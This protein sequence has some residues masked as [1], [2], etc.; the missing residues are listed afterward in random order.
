MTLQYSDLFAV[1][2]GATFEQRVQVAMASAAAAVYAESGFANTSA[3]SASGLKTLQFA[4]ATF[5]S[6]VV[7]G[8]IIVD[9]TAPAGISSG[10]II[11][12]IVT[13]GGTT[14]LTLS[15]PLTGT[16]GTGDT[17]GFP[18][19]ATRAAFANRVSQGNY[20]LQAA[21]VMVFSN[22]TIAAEAALATA[23]NSIPDTDLQFAVNS[24]WNMMAGT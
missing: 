9:L 2:A 17:V 15:S 14:T 20:N 22:P 24:L 5:P 8:S 21:A 19:H 6:W 12:N 7:P 1:S 10:T 18:A 23:N 11:S 16:I 4:A 3:G 13:V